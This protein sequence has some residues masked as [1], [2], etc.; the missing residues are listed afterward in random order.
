VSFTSAALLFFLVIDP[1]GGIPFILTALQPVP[2]ERRRR[3]L[4]RELLLAYG[5]MV[6]FLFAGSSLLNVLQISEPALTIAG[7]VILFLIALRLVFPSPDRSLQEDFQGEPFLVPLAIPYLAGPSLLATESLLMSRE[8]H[9]WPEWLGALTVAWLA[10]GV[11]LLLAGQLSAL[12]GRRGLLAM[13]RL[14][15]MILV[16]LAVEMFLS[17]FARYVHELP[18]R[19]EPLKE[20]SAKSFAKPFA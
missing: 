19:N 15:G 3:V 5:V 11:I 8:P 17:G 20:A 6:G 1:L 18:R 13:E 14:T 4:L 12:L 10:A 7:G 16:A 2:P 9:R